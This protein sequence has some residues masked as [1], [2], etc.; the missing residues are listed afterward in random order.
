MNLLTVLLGTTAIVGGAVGSAVVIDK[1]APLTLYPLAKKQ[2]F[3]THIKPT[4]GVIIWA[5][6]SFHDFVISY[7]DHHL[8]RPGT[9]Y[10]K[11]EFPAW[12]VLENPEGAT[13]ADYDERPQ[14]MKDH[15]Y[16]PIGIP[17]KRQVG[18]YKF[19]WLIA[20]Q[21]SSFKGVPGV[22][23]EPEQNTQVYLLGW[24]SYMVV[25]V[26]IFTAD[27]YKVK[28]GAL[29]PMRINNPY[30]AI[31]ETGGNWMPLVDG[32]IGAAIKNFI[33]KFEF[34]DLISL[35]DE[36]EGSFKALKENFAIELHKTNTCLFGEQNLPKKHQQGT[37]GKYGVTTGHADLCTV[38]PD[39]PQSEQMYQ[40]ILAQAAADIQAGV[41]RTDAD[42]AAYVTTTTGTAAANVTKLQ[43]E[44]AAHVT[45]ATGSATAK[46][47]RLQGEAAAAGKAAEYKAAQKHREGATLV[48]SEHVFAIPPAASAVLE[49]VAKRI[50]GDP[51]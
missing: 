31:I 36:K 27:G 11:K 23:Q 19:S 43:G 22:R 44:A 5:G 16:F 17:F 2:I 46:V 14:W 35:S 26:D 13:D 10:F 21:D 9:W 50:S 18:Y 15:G 34:K 3:I 32:A 39:G 49:A 20:D 25:V 48:E 47:T 30:L 4:R 51:K 38:V 29:V 28:V 45:M 37:A 41:R 6:T 7:P 40:L 24:T 12:E 42:A 33:G 1:V 8:N